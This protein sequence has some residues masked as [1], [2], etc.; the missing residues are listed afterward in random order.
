MHLADVFI[1]SD[2]HWSAGRVRGVLP[3]DPYWE[4]VKKE[5]R[6]FTEFTSRN[7]TFNR[8]LQC[9]KKVFYF[10]FATVKC[11]EKHLTK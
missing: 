10:F 11:N 5:K 1:Q 4:L 6:S 3:K 2:L 9:F 7:V 8:I